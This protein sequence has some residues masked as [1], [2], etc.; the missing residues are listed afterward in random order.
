MAAVKALTKLPDADLRPALVSALQLVAQESET[1]ERS[2]EIMNLLE[3]LKACGSPEEEIVPWFLRFLN[4]PESSFQYDRQNLIRLSASFRN[5][6]QYGE[7]LRAKNWEIFYSTE[8]WGTV[9]A[10]LETVDLTSPE[11][12]SQLRKAFTIKQPNLR[13]SAVRALFERHSVDLDQEPELLKSLRADE[14][15]EVRAWGVH[16][17]ISVAQLQIA[18]VSQKR[19]ILAKALSFYEDDPSDQVRCAIVVSVGAVL[20]SS[21]PDVRRE[22]LRDVALGLPRLFSDALKNPST[23]SAA[24]EQIANIAKVRPIERPNPFPK[25][26]AALLWKEIVAAAEADVEQN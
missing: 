6:G 13:K 2:L 21:A 16:A 15:E 14:S 7:L 24:A 9:L 3:A 11:T 4:E 17:M 12:L 26:R 19:S 20:A 25:E 5:S 23:A 22:L 8:D 10:I 18:P 1:L